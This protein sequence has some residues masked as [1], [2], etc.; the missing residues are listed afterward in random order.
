M[1]AADVAG[2]ILIYHA[3]PHAQDWTTLSERDILSSDEFCNTIYEAKKPALT[4][5]A[6]MILRV[7]TADDTEESDAEA[8]AATDGSDLDDI[9]LA[10]ETIRP[11]VSALLQA[12]RTSRHDL[13][14]AIAEQA[15]EVDKMEDEYG[16]SQKIEQ[17]SLPDRETRAFLSSEACCHE[18]FIP[19]GCAIDIVRLCSTERRDESI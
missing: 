13:L 4:L 18:L 5:D 2:W 9:A 3:V 12:W 10:D 8:N 16:V 19:C 7:C 11:A 15:A 14:S 1:S 6:S 17:L